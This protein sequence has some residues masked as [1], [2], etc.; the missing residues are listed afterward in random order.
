MSPSISSPSRIRSRSLG[1]LLAAGC[2]GNDSAGLFP[3]ATCG[4]AAAGA[5]AADDAGVD[6]VSPNEAAGSGAPP[7][8]LSELVFNELLLLLVSGAPDDGATVSLDAM[9]SRSA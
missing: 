4:A 6:V 8:P 9:G 5:G 1:P 2:S 3:S 7:T